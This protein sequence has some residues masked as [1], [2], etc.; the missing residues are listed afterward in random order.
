MINIYDNNLK[1]IMALNN[2]FT[3]L[4]QANTTIKE[5]YPDF[6]PNWYATETFFNYPKLVNGVLVEKTQEELKLEL[7]IPLVDGEF[8]QDNKIIT[9]DKPEGY[10]IIWQNN[11]WI[12]LATEEEI[13]EINYKDSVDFYNEELAFASKAT[14]ELACTIISE[15]EFEDV[16]AYMKAIEPYSI[17]KLSRPPR[18][19]IFNRYN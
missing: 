16:K 10:N 12:E 1:F 9:I 11:K 15:L 13:Q 5:S 2:T 8:I 4:E 14:A 17:T 19:S 7:I 18:P 6:Q 3:E